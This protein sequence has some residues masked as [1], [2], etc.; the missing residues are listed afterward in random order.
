MDDPCSIMTAVSVVRNES[1]KQIGHYEKV[2]RKV[3]QFLF[4]AGSEPS[5][6]PDSYVV[7]E[8]EVYGKSYNK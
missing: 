1:E 3:K 2:T 7:N 8:K 6:L 4:V 5:G